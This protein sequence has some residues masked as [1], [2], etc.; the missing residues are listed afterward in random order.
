[1]L[2]LVVS[3]DECPLVCFAALLGAV[4]LAVDDVDCDEFE[5]AIMCLNLLVSELD[6]A[7]RRLLARCSKSPPRD[8]GGLVCETTAW[9]DD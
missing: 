4:V 8:C 2:L 7:D 3:V 1:L 5:E 9:P 6:D